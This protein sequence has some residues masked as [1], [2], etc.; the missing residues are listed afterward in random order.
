MSLRSDVAALPRG[1]WVLF[2]GTLINRLGSFVLFFLILYLTQRGYSPAR[3]GLTLSAYGVGGVFA[4]L[5]GGHLADTIG[6]RNTIVA[7]MFLSAATLMLLSQAEAMWQ[8]ALWTGLTGL[9]AELYRPAS[10]ALIAD[11]TKQGDRVTAFAVYRIAINLGVA[12]GPA[13]GGFLADRNFF[14][15]FVADAVTAVMFGLVAL[16]AIPN[17]RGESAEPVSPRRAASVITGDRGFL[18]FLVASLL[19]GI[20]FMQFN[21]TLPLQVRAFGYPNAVYGMIMSLNGALVLL[22]E[23]PVTR[24]TARR[25]APPVIALGLVLVGVGYGLTPLGA[26]AVLLFSSVAVW[27]LGEIVFV[28]VA[29]AH[30]ADLSPGH[31]RG[32]YQGAWTA[33]WGL[34]HI[35]APILGT[36]VYQ[37]STFAVWMMCIAAGL[38]AAV[39]VLT[40]VPAARSP[41]AAE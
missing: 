14:L 40:G 3:A 23:L 16:F 37:H 9:T 6:R 25:P 10:A 39:V 19:G 7:S 36:A 30:V 26:S 28:P 5:I 27:T 41:H 21:S 12:V 34:T 35:L 33:T 29:A 13:I 18:M 1:V 24:F 31:M 15:V 32:R 8:I 38:A 11:L 4:S 17:T 22:L 2:A 20:A